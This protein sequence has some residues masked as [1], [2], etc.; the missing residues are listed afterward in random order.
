M[1]TATPSPD[2]RF[3]MPI[4]DMVQSIYG[5]KIAHNDPTF[6]YIFSNLKKFND[7]GPVKFAAIEGHGGAVPQYD[8]LNDRY[9]L[10]TAE[11]MTAALDPSINQRPLIRGPFGITLDPKH[12]DDLDYLLRQMAEAGGAKKGHHVTFKLFEAQNRPAEYLDSLEIIT[13]LRQEG[14]DVGCEVAMVVSDKPDLDMSY[15]KEAAAGLLNPELFASRGIDPA[16]IEGFSAKDMIG[17]IRASRADDT[18][19]TINARNLAHVM[20][21]AMQNFTRQTGQKLY[22]GWHSHQIGNGV[23]CV[24]EAGVTFHKERAAYPEITEFQQDALMRSLDTSVV[25]DYG[26]IDLERLLQ[27]YRDAGIMEGMNDAQ[28]EIWDDFKE[29]MMDLATRHREDYIDV[30]KWSRELLEYGQLASGGMAFV[31]K[32]IIGGYIGFIARQEM[33]D[34]SGRRVPVGTDKAGRILRCLFASMNGAIARDMGNAHSVTPAMLCLNKLAAEAMTALMKDEDRVQ[35]IISSSR[36]SWDLPLR[37]PEWR[38]I[39]RGFYEGFKDVKSMGYFCTPMPTPLSEDMLGRLRRKLYEAHYPMD[40]AK[41]ADVPHNNSAS[42]L[43]GIGEE[44]YYALREEMVGNLLDKEKTF[45][46]LTRYGIDPN[47][48]RDFVTSH[49]GIDELPVNHR[50]KSYLGRIRE[51][52]EKLVRDTGGPSFKRRGLWKTGRD[53]VDHI[54]FGAMVNREP[55]GGLLPHKLKIMVAR[56]AFKPEGSWAKHLAGVRPPNVTARLAAAQTPGVKPAA[57]PEPA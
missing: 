14:Y 8:M 49:I 26:F 18:G 54:V 7:A 12:K 41:L 45:E 57:A 44:K 10:I 27:R 40:Y 35:K 11:N 48:A 20:M 23:D 31:E 43:K 15:Y 19:A 53:L 36:S 46:I 30:S 9:P 38:D 39:F 42:M 56:L 32:Q 51:A 52:A 1:E 17:G 25:R 4:R 13:K 50:A 47:V 5:G 2:F 16:A 21:D 28:Y 34:A 24:V 33:E 55:T 3:V 22:L 29:K 37:G 6:L